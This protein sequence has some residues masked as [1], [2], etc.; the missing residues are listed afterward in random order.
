MNLIVKPYK[1]YMDRHIGKSAA[2]GLLT[3][4]F[5]AK[6]N[7]EIERALDKAAPSWNDPLQPRH[8]DRRIAVMALQHVKDPFELA[9]FM[10]GIPHPAPLTV[11]W[12]KRVAANNPEALAPEN[13]YA[14]ENPELDSVIR[15]LDDHKASA[16]QI[17]DVVHLS[18]S[19]VRKRLQRVRQMPAPTR[20]QH[21]FGFYFL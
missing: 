14:R 18:A 13:R 7:W 19:T 5:N 16:R 3:A 21:S 9:D 6:S 2:D 8:T 11:Q 17:A 4:C 12:F 1:Q 20:E 15:F 10:S